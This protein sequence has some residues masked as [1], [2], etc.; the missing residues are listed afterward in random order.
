MRLQV[1]GVPGAA[2]DR[3]LRDLRVRVPELADRS[4]A[5]VS[6]V[7]FVVRVQPAHVPVRVPGDGDAVH[8]S[9]RVQ[10]TTLRV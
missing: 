3:Q 4:H 8:A 5:S 1:R 9:L 7:S 6:G 2:G 10:P